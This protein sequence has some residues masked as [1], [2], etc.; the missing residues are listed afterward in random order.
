LQTWEYIWLTYSRT[1]SGYKLYHRDGKRFVYEDI[2]PILEYV[3]QLGMNGWELVSAVGSPETT[4]MFF[5]R[6]L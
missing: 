2:N 5:K 4:T 1:S 3:D 6:P